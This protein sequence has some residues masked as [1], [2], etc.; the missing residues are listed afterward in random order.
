MNSIRQQLFFSQALIC[1]V[2]AG[3]LLKSPLIRINQ[4]RFLGS[5]D[6]QPWSEN[7]TIDPSL[8]L[9]LNKNIAVIPLEFSEVQQLA[10]I[11]TPQEG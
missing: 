11:T 5:F 1:G 10:Q 4:R 6:V 9:H 8:C 3:E 7:S 2:S